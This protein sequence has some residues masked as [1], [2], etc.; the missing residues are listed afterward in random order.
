MLVIQWLAT[1]Q[2]HH[3]FLMVLKSPNF[4][5]WLIVASV[6]LPQMQQ[7]M[8]FNFIPHEISCLSH[9]FICCS[10]TQQMDWLNWSGFNATNNQCSFLSKEDVTFTSCLLG[11]REIKPL[12]F[13]ASIPTASIFILKTVPLP[14]IYCA[15]CTSLKLP[16]S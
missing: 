1:I 10:V 6:H 7:W 9:G 11:V 4:S 13:N 12:P 2:L 16:S 15:S 3:H 14:L 8:L 5:I